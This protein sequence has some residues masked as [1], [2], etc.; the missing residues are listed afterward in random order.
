MHLQLSTSALE[1][2]FNCDD[3]DHYD[4]SNLLKQLAELIDELENHTNVDLVITSTKHVD[5][6]GAEDED[7]ND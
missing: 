1:I 2:S 4:H 7:W 3:E 5:Q 6:D